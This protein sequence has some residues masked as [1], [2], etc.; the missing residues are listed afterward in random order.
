M[1]VANDTCSFGVARPARHTQLID[2][3]STEGVEGWPIL[4]HSPV[5]N[6]A[7]ADAADSEADGSLDQSLHVEA[8]EPAADG[9]HDD[10]TDTTATA[11]ADDVDGAETGATDAVDGTLHA[12]CHMPL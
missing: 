12:D 7:A 5:L 1:L 8:S 9:V 2:E 6:E 10:A 11:T 4:L 3:L